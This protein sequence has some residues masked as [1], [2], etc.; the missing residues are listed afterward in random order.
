MR[1]IVLAGLAAL[2][3]VAL[4]V[5]NWNYKQKEAA[6]EA[7]EQA[8]QTAE[9]ALFTSRT[10]A[11]FEIEK[12]LKEH[13]AVSNGVLVVTYTDAAIMWGQPIPLLWKVSCSFLGLTLDLG[14]RDN[15]TGPQITD[16]TLTPEFIRITDAN[17]SEEQCQWLTPLLGQKLNAMFLGG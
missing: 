15:S 17:L 10:A 6:K 1:I 5:W 8:Q 7:Q 4:Y 13:I 9:A 14:Q 11:E 2:I 3:V 16:V 12:R